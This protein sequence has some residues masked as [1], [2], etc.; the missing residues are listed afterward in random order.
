MINNLDSLPIWSSLMGL[1]KSSQFTSYKAF[2]K[3][4]YF[5]ITLAHNYIN[6]EI[7]QNLLELPKFQTLQAHLQDWS[8]GRFD[9]KLRPNYIFLRKFSAVEHPYYKNATEGRQKIQDIVDKIRNGQ[10]LGYDGQRITDVVN[11]GIGGS[12][13]GPRMTV[14]ALEPFKTTHLR[15][16]F[17]S[18]ADPYVLAKTLQSLNPQTSLF[19]VSSKSFNTEETLQNAAAVQK[20]FNQPNVLMHHMIA[21]T[22]NPLKAKSLGYQHVLPIWDWVIGRYS[23]CS[24]INLI[25]ALMI[26]FSEFENF[27]K[28]AHAMDEHFFNAPISENIPVLLALLGIW[29]INFLD[30]RSHLLLIYDYRLRHFVDYVQ[31]MDMESNGKSVNQD[32]QKIDYCTGPIIWGGLGNQ[33]HHSYYQLLAQGKHRLGIDFITTSENDERL[34]NQLCRNRLDTLKNGVSTPHFQEA[35]YPQTSLNHIHLRD[36]TPASLGALIAMYEHKVFAQAWLWNINPFDQPG[37]ESAKKNI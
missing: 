19:L 21:I 36:L 10:W 32:Y 37:V 31:Q 2:L 9:S 17:I 5:D 12:D 29:N 15:F 24:A 11:I 7:F 25:L 33:A 27:L 28:G 22:A 8:Q 1:K 30:I 35:I 34:I 3:N 20:W 18:D 26:G 23:C 14:E 6:Q 16:H 4:D 13:L